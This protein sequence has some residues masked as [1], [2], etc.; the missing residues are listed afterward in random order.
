MCH[1]ARPVHHHFW[2]LS[3]RVGCVSI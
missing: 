3:H 2:Y 1:L